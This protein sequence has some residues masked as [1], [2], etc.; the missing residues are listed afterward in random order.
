M[1]YYYIVAYDISNNKLRSKV[2]KFLQNHGTRIQFSVFCCRLTPK[3]LIK[4]KED[5]KKLIVT[6]P[7]ASI[8]FV[9]SG[10][11]IDDMSLPEVE[12][13]GNKWED[14]NNDNVI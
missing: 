11:V 14:P 7:T 10:Q 4:L 9:K 2:A 8:L 6:E 1:R 5:L 13:I 12:W 3:E